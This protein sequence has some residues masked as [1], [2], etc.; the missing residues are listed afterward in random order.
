MVGAVGWGG[1]FAGGG[2]L[3]LV[4]LAAGVGHVAWLRAADGVHV[5]AT[6][7]DDP[8]S[9][10]EKAREAAEKR[11]LAKG[12]PRTG[13][14]ELRVFPDD[15]RWAA[16]A[17]S[18]VGLD[19]SDP[20]VEDLRTGD[21][22][23]N[24]WM[25]FML[26][27]GGVTDACS[28]AALA[29]NADES[30]L[31]QEKPTST[32]YASQVESV[33]WPGPESEYECPAGRAAFTL[34]DNEGR[35][36][37]DGI[38][39]SWTLTLDVPTRPILSIK[40]GTVLNQDAHHA[41]L[42]V[43]EAGQTLTV[44][45][46]RPEARET[47]NGLE[48]TEEQSDMAH[49]SALLQ[50][51]T[52]QREAFWMVAALVAVMVQWVLPFVREWAPSSTRRRWTVV[53]VAACGLTGALTLYGLAGSGDLPWP[54][55]LYP[56]RGTL[57]AVWSLVLLPF[58]LA[59]FLVRFATGRAPRLRELLPILLPS[60]VLPVLAGVFAVVEGTS[61]PLVSLGGAAL[62]T[63]S[64]AYALRRGAVGAAGRRWAV[65]AAGGAWLTVLAAA[66]GTGLP[67]RE[68][69]H[70]VWD[71]GNA[72]AVV[73]MEW[74]WY[75]V[76]WHIVVTVDRRPWLRHAGWFLMAAFF[77]SVAVA[78][79]WYPMWLKGDGEVWHV[80]G[81]YPTYAASFPV[82][83][84]GLVLLVALALLRVHDSWY[85][86]WPPYVRFAAVGAGI[87]A[88]G[89]GLGAYGLAL[90]GDA[91]QRGGY[92]ISILVAAIG[93]AWL[94]PPEAE[95]RAVR[96]HDADLAAHNRLVHA[97]LKNQ[98]LTAGR[99]EFL[100]TSRTELAEG[101]LTAREW[102]KRWRGLGA[103]AT[104]PRHTENL[105]RAALGT[106]GGRTTLSN[107]AAAGMLLMVLS[108]PWMA[109]TVPTPL[110]DDYPYDTQLWAYALR[111]AV[112][113]F[114]YGYVYSWLRGGSP[115]G[116]ALCL[117]AVVL[118][119]ELAQLLY[120]G[121]VP[122]DFA[123]SLLLTTGNCLAVFLVLGLYWEA[124]LVR[125]AG[126]RWG[127]IR[128]FR[129]L[130]TAAVPATTVLVASATA[131]ATAMVGVWIVPD[132]SPAPTEP[133]AESS[134]SAEPSPKP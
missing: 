133:G 10:E 15:G 31:E 70:W 123:V 68:D 96:L 43:Q 106:S 129:S 8:A 6:A 48:R 38:Y 74:G 27:L 85:E 75:A 23:L 2:L 64:V 86:G 67:Q 78:Q 128:N 22:E 91:S 54:S 60:A 114:V 71:T 132:N 93:F 13:S 122:K 26:Y 59:A 46:G 115:I 40:G 47:P 104:A 58:L 53:A 3:L 33:T 120:R 57:L 92:Y 131:L 98:T 134:V 16:V 37:G 61:W 81:R 84:L 25:P 35:L 36:G 49:L 32:A 19:P 103:R 7:G 24:E 99:R 12:R 34:T 41:E 130:S 30:R 62:A 69:P 117:L 14:T 110:S 9:A 39:D 88:V 121:L 118:P 82:S 119:A 111:W 55:W 126:L 73:A 17:K 1:R 45:L 11:Y 100:T 97:L 127:Q 51:E 108:V 105:R 65:T 66:P 18:T 90:F 76:V 101:T 79:G 116:K 20:M 77:A 112:Y 95:D 80:I 21:Q 44:V 102:S 83:L 94:L 63:A 72:L 42:R 125:A 113:G 56:G 124:R 52:P 87:A 89:T 4:L 109:Y 5:E 107:G 29:G 28:W 50:K